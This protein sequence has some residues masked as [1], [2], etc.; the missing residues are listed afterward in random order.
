MKPR[1][2]SIG[3]KKLEILKDLGQGTYGS[4]YLINVNG[5]LKAI[6]VITN[7]KKDG[8]KSLRELDIMSRLVHPNLV[9]AEGLMVGVSEILTVGIIMPLATTDLQ[10]LLKEPSFTN[11]QRIGILKDITEGVKFLHD[12]G[13]V[14]LDL[15]PMNVLIFNHGNNKIGKIT[16]FGLSLILER[17]MYNQMEKYY[18][19]ELVTI[20][21][22]PPEVLNGNLIYIKANDVWSLG[23]IFLEVLSHGKPLYSD[24]TKS[25]IKATN[26]K[27]LGPGSIDITLDVYLNN[28]PSGMKR[29]AKSIIKRMLDFNPF[30]RATINEV[31]KSDLFKNHLDNIET[32]HG[33]EIYQRPEPPRSCDLVYYYGFDWLVRLSMN[34]YIKLETFYLAADIYQRA[35]AYS[36]TLTGNFD[37]DISN[38][39]LLATTSL[40]MA[41]KI[42]ESYYP[43]RDKLVML[44]SNRFMV[45]D[46][47]KTEAALTQLFKGIL[48][49]KNLFTESNSRE[50]MLYG[51]EVLRNCHV[52]YRIDLKRWKKDGNVNHTYNKY[53]IRYNDFIKETQYFKY[54]GMD[55][56]EYLPKLFKEDINIK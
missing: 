31:L 42:V 29:D 39:I 41:I 34:F 55:Q 25:K 13:Y 27:L 20:T 43:E 11:T 26:K 4:V 10:R 1:I 12:K 49:S 7:K 9:R 24:F 44:S 50:V 45:D 56:K 2:V 3:D 33:M 38:S 53:Q 17:N 22:R 5:S 47:T 40:Y 18:P 30:S 37:I 46:I 19:T 8:I 15:K 23:I 28:L 6:K 16:D 21:H 35:L 36:H 52:Y 48:Y 54:L 14:H 32:S 51:F